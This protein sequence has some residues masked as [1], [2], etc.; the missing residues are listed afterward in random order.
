M[1]WSLALTCALLGADGAQTAAAPSANSDLAAYK[2]A[3]AKLGKNAD[4]QVR[5]AMWCEAHGLSAERVKHLALA[6]LYDPTNALARGLMGMVSFQGKWAHP[7]DVSRAMHDDPE[8]QAV[9]SEY[10]DRRVKTASKAEAQLRLAAWCDEHGLKEQAIA[11]YNEVIRL[12]PAQ[13]IAWRHLGYKK[14][15][16]QWVKPEEAAAEK[17]QAERQKR[18]D[19]IWR[20]KLERLREGL[21]S[22]DTARRT[23]AQEELAQI[24]DPAAL[25]MIWAVFLQGNERNQ[26]A[27]VQML[28]QIDGS[29]AS[30]ALAVLA[31]FNP[32]AEVR[33]RAAE[34]LSRRDP[35]DVVGRL[36]EL[37]KKPFKYRYTPPGGP[38]TTGELFVEG[39]RFNIDRFY[40]NNPVNPEWI[41]R[42]LY[43]ASVPFDPYSVQNMM[44]ATVA[45]APQ[46]F[47]VSSPT[48]SA[49]SGHIH[50]SVG[51]LASQA[52][53]PATNPFFWFQVQAAERDQMIARALETIQQDQLNLEARMARDIQMIE[54][55]NAC[56]K[57][58]N[59]R[60]LPLLK[61]LSGKDID[62]EPDKWK[63]W[64]TDQLGYVYQAASPTAK[65]TFTDF[66]SEG[67][68]SGPVHSACFAAG[69]LVKTLDGPRA[70]ESIKVGDRVLTQNTTTG[71]L[72]FQP[73]LVI[74]RNEPTATLRI[75]VGDETIV[76]TGIH[77][78]WKPGKGW[79]MARELKAGDALRM[80][81]GTTKVKSVETGETQPVF[82]LDI[83]QDRDFFVGNAGLL[84]HDFSFV[85][86]VPEPFDRPA[87][88]GTAAAADAGV[89]RATP[90]K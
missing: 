35:R 8:R 79:T 53:D 45:S 74:H 81:G 3:R 36:I 52:M 2:E 17:K 88:L 68:L 40:R 12:D 14:Q 43:A 26:L 27:A 38:G 76:A 65:P 37:I 25:P 54:S 58:V 11:H 46:S 42:R 15:G 30:N 1:F 33:S 87:D 66:V 6:V 73:V 41:P 85:Q 49:N 18:A 61:L 39:E 10:L 44:L 55:T 64:W 57:L 89:A 16:S 60:A 32:S 78:F 84:V 47:A 48:L 67:S 82:N 51:P 19:K 75:A 21:V 71:H 69:S 23:K 62:A 63:G 24:S 29:S 72:A 20:P 28:A 56:I 77:R 59:S 50:G 9:I 83:A 90:E 13:Q 80:V 86:P 22:K 4:A 31:V 34:S 5:M 70:I 7:E